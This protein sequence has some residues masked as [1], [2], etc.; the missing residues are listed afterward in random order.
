[1]EG[2]VWRDLS[3]RAC[4]SYYLDYYYDDC[5]NP[6]TTTMTARIAARPITNTTN[7]TTTTGTMTSIVS[8]VYVHIDICQKKEIDVERRKREGELSLSFLK[9]MHVLSFLLYV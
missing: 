1:M 9:D 5:Y 4:C 2:I 6:C 3:D 7:T 8:G